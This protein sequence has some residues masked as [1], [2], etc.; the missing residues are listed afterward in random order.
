[1]LGDIDFFTSESVKNK[2]GQRLW[3]EFLSLVKAGG[4]VYRDGLPVVC[5]TH[6][7]RADLSSP[8]AF[9]ENVPCGGCRVA[10]GAALACDGGHPCPRRYVQG[11]GV[12]LL[13]FSAGPLTKNASFLI[14]GKFVKALTRQHP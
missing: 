4:H 8:E 6:G 3:L 1:M 12:E 10:C 5:E 2:S 7:T 14:P 13:D 9:D 11:G